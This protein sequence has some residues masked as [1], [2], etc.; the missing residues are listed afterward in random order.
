PVPAVPQ[1]GPPQPPQIPPAGAPPS[2]M[3]AS[4]APPMAAPV[5]RG[6]IT[7]GVLMG[8]VG[9]VLAVVAIASISWFVVEDLEGTTTMKFGLREIEIRFEGFGE[10]VEERE[11]YAT[12]Q[13]QMGGELKMDNVAHSTF[14]LLLVGLI[15]AALFILFGL[16]AAIGMFRGFLT[17]MP[18][19]TGL[20]AGILIV[21]AASYFGIA[22]QDAMEE[23]IDQNLADQEDAK[24]GLGGVW[25]LALFGGILVLLGALMTKAPTAVYSQTEP[26]RQG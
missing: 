1:G 14:W 15:L 21:I 16:F 10:T 12:L 23:D 13:N 5:P 2:Q 18:L 24:Y 11:T 9:L 6:R 25:Y 22:F 17:W 20:V 3:P 26:M 8:A 4:R 7:I 19:L